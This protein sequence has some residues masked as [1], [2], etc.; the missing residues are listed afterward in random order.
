MSEIV[1][2]MQQ[3][4]ITRSNLF[5]QQT[6]GTKDE[7]N[8]YREHIQYVYQYVL[9]L[10]KD[11]NVDIEVLK[12]SALLHD[13]AM[14]DINL[15]RS[16]HNEDG[17]IIAEQLLRE[18]NYP[19]DKVQFVKKCILNHSSKRSEYR[20]TEEE[21][22]LVNADGLSHFDSIHNLYNLAHNV[23]EL[24]DDET[25]KFIKDK[26]TKDYNEI[27]DEL[28][29]LIDDKYNN[30]MTAKSIKDIILTPVST[31]IGTRK[32]VLLT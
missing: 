24:N 28:K 18:N 15:D 8:I 6:K 12:L 13:I 21:K 23:M 29:Y 1:E 32:H 26:L 22:I 30:I 11:K 16:K 2:K 17:A 3:E 5:E 9:L 4:I 31:K 27:S 20:T 14:T 10:S 7:Y 19:E 25:L